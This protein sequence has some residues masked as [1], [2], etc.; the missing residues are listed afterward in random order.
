MKA[1]RLLV[2]RV[3]N[4]VTTIVDSPCKAERKAGKGSEVRES[5]FLAPQRTARNPAA[6]GG[7]LPSVI[8]PAGIT[9]GPRSVTEKIWAEAKPVKSRTAA[10]NPRV[11][12]I[13][14]SFWGNS[15]LRKLD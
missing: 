3:A 5:R 14:C 8:D 1:E 6:Q 7:Y 4:Y 12:V 9:L 15:S 11:I 13:S 10:S 2:L